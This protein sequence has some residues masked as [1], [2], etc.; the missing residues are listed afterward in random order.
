MKSA[1]DLVHE[2]RKCFTIEDGEIAVRADLFEKIVTIQSDAMEHCAGIV[3]GAK[4]AP[5]M[6][7]KTAERDRATCDWITAT[8]RA[9]KPEVGS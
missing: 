2:I 4:P 1:N 5:I 7:G 9:A 8:I 3:E 6:G